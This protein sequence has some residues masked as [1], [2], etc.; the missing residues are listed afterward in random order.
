[1]RLKDKESSSS[2]KFCKRNPNIAPQYA[3]IIKVVNANGL[4]VHA[5]QSIWSRWAREIEGEDEGEGEGKADM[6]EGEGEADAVQ[7]KDT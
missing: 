5:F 3:S 4:H 2:R 7:V 6:V 1:M